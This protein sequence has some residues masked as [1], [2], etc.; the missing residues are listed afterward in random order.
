MSSEKPIPASLKSGLPKWGF[1]C[2]AVLL[3]VVGSASAG[4]LVAP[5]AVIMDDHG[6]GGRLNIFNNGDTPM[7]V[8]ISLS[9]GL[10]ESDSVGNVNVVLQDSAVTDPRCAMDWMK[11][12]PRK[13]I[14]PPNATQ[15]VRFIARP[16]RDLPDGEYWARVVVESTEGAISVPAANAAEEITTKLNMVMRTAVMVKYRSGDCSTGVRLNAAEAR[17]VDT[18]RVEVIAD[19]VNTG[20]ASYVG[21]LQGRLLDAKNREVFKTQA[22]LAVY[23]DLRRRLD[24]FIPAG[25]FEPPFRVE[26]LVTTKGRR[27]IPEEEM[28]SGNEVST[29]VTLTEPA[30]SGG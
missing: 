23:Y 6:S 29:V 21:L 17:M 13:L 3:V 18:N 14:V 25:T 20:N 12:F 19:L 11:A 8:T 5:A 7:E 9:F 1:F 15:V 28:I 24:F 4:V 10:P 22:Q 30:A 26:L 16:P 2:L 27:D